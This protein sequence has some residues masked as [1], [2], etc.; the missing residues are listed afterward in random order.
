MAFVRA[1]QAAGP[2][3]EF[4]DDL[5]VATSEDVAGIVAE[6]NSREAAVAGGKFADAV[7][8]FDIPEPGDAIT[9][10][11]DEEVAAELD[12]VDGPAMTKQRPDDVPGVAVPDDDAGVFGAG[13]DV[14]VIKANV[15]DASGVAEEAA[16]G[17][18]SLGIPD[19]A[20]VVRRTRYHDFGIVLQA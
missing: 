15:E 2:R 12:G 17:L 5:I 13:D 10:S 20:G 6:L 1:D 14:F 16:D 4:V 19:D 7:A 3:I 18:E 9:G 8:G 11:G